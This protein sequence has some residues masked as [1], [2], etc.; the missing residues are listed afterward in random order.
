MLIKFSS[1]TLNKCTCLLYAPL[2]A[3]AGVVTRS[4]DANDAG[5]IGTSGV[6]VTG[7]SGGD[8]LWHATR[9]GYVKI[10]YMYK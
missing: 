7:G 10:T 6:G 3:Q 8:A 9:F 2:M 5:V 4:V 1:S